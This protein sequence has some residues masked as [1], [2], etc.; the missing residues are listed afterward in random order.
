MRFFFA[1]EQLEH[2]ARQLKD[3]RV[4]ID[5]RSLSIAITGI[6]RYTLEISKHLSSL[7]CLD[8]TFLSPSTIPP[9]VK[10]ELGKVNCVEGGLSGDIPRFI[11][12]ETLL[13][14]LLRKHEIDLYWN[15]AHRIPLFLPARVASVV[16]IHDLTWYFYPQTMRALLRWA[17]KY[18]MPYALRHAD[19]I[20]AVSESTRRSILEL[21]RVDHQRCSTVLHGASTSLCSGPFRMRR[22]TVVGAPYLLFVGTVEP[23]KNLPRLL[24]AFAKARS[25]L[26]NNLQLMIAGGS[27]WG[28][29]ELERLIDLHQL[30]DHVLVRGYV[31]D[32]ELTS[33]YRDALALVMP[34]L[35]E[36]FGLPIL[37]AMV[38][39]LPVITSNN[40]SMA[41]IVGDA[42][43]LVDPLDI[44]SIASAIMRLVGDD[45]LRAEL[46]HKSRNQAALFCW[47]TSAGLL[48]DCFA[49]AV[50]RYDKS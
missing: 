34:S 50:A 37:E 49:T 8:L 26:D 13:P 36:G 45:C 10:A 15:P 28:N 2:K 12:G 29:V 40:S 6:G 9:S 20:V 23:R 21:Y 35:Y 27:G 30:G 39:G 16:T 25:S 43:L 32:E 24:E 7:K 1:S 19:H 42:A 17:E 3:I 46:S 41:E 31:S 38:N 48:L 5:A 14:W 47:A 11:W 44:N 4:G 18:Q 22:D 33:I